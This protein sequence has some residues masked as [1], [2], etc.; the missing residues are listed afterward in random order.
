MLSVSRYLAVGN[1][2]YT[3]KVVDK[4]GKRQGLC[5]PLPFKLYA[6]NSLSSKSIFLQIDLLIILE[7]DLVRSLFIFKTTIL[8][9]A[10]I[11]YNQYSWHLKHRVFC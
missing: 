6:T 10:R 5:F 7:Y 3:T 9:D 2:S 4:K 11:Y 8:K 1:D